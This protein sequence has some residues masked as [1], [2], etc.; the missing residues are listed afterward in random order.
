MAATRYRR[1]CS[2]QAPESDEAR[3][4]LYR[5]PVA[6][7]VFPLAVCTTEKAQLDPQLLVL[8]LRSHRD[9][10]FTQCT[11][12]GQTAAQSAAHVHRSVTLPVVHSAIARWCA[13]CGGL[14]GRR[15]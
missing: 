2:R 8:R 7:S 6:L 15:C 11:R 12:V 9:W 10:L 1:P 4:S 5:S 14:G 3:R 13:A